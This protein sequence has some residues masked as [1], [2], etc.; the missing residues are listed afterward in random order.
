VAQCA[1][2]RDAGIPI[3]VAVNLSTR[4]LLESDLPEEVARLLG[5]FDLP[6]NMLELEVTEAGIMSDETR[7]DATLDRLRALGVRIAVDDFGT[8]E[9]SYSRLQHLPIDILKIDKSFIFALDGGGR[10]VSIVKSMI[11]LGR[12]LGLETVAEGAETGAAFTLLHE[13]GCDLVQGYHVSRP[14]PADEL[15]R[16]LTV[17]TETT[18]M[19]ERTARLRHP[20]PT[21]A[22]AP[23]DRSHLV[24]VGGPGHTGRGG[25]RA[26]A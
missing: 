26:S 1:S 7:G 21:A 3:S 12:N 10:E 18:A 6:A 17:S 25:S 22:R 5:R 20:A 13:L 2:W 19:I 9:S 4:N 11:D 15:T 8:G 24:V 16:H 14:L 23:G